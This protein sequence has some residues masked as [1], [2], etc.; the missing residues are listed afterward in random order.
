LPVTGAYAQ[1]PGEVTRGGEVPRIVA[2][3]Q[4]EAGIDLTTEN[5]FR[6]VN[7]PDMIYRRFK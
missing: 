2:V 6:N 1:S 3:E 5:V 7:D 4:R